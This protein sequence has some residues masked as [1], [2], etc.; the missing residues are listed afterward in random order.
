MI[1]QEKAWDLPPS[2]QSS[3]NESS[4]LWST[5]SI[6]GTEI[7]EY[8]VRNK[9]KALISV[10]SAASSSSSAAPIAATPTVSTNQKVSQQ[11]GHNSASHIGGTWGEEEDSSNVWTGVHSGV[12][13]TASMA[14]G[15]VSAIAA[16][17]MNANNNHSA[18]SGKNK[19]LLF[20]IFLLKNI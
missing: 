4:S 14:T 11:W 7:W 13:A 18:P 8:T 6:T 2:L 10:A 20:Y 9:T 12:S 1:N 15:G 5:G 3:P 19:I 16:P 17:V